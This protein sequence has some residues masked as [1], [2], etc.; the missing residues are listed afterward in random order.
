MFL[1]LVE[2]LVRNVLNVQNQIIY[3]AANNPEQLGK[4]NAFKPVEFGAS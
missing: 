1:Y 4:I 2:R 3:F